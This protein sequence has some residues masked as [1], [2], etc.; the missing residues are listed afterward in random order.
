[1]KSN[2]ITQQRAIVPHFLYSFSKFS[3]FLYLL[4]SSL[5]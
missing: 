4:T 2:V 3:I 5:K 1:V